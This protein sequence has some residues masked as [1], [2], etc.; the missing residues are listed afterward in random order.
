[1]LKSVDSRD[2]KSRGLAAVRVQ[3]PPR[4]P[5]SDKD[6]IIHAYIIGIALGDG[7]LSRP[8]GRTTRLRITCDTKYPTIIQEITSALSQ[9][10][11]KNKVSIVPGP[12]PTY[13]NVSVYSEKLNG[14]LPWKVNN[15]SKFLQQAHIPMWIFEDTDYHIAVL[16]GLIQTDG[17]I[18]KDRTYTMINF[19]SII[20]PL[21]DDVAKL[22]ELLG[23]KP[24]KSKTIQKSGKTKYTIR[25]ARDTDYFL[26]LTGIHK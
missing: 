24:T 7:N 16:K 2:S 13:C 9:L 11:P 12:K 26:K 23:F 6:K 8:N 10:L 18:Y 25:L 21:A 17:S 14:L 1:V 4:P 3:V 22:M 15:G 19:T 5:V 20:E